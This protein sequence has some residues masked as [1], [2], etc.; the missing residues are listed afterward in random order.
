MVLTAQHFLVSLVF[1][2]G[3]IYWNL[4]DVWERNVVVNFFSNLIWMVI[5]GLNPVIYMLVNR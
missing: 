4:I 2:F 5:N 1:V 3:F